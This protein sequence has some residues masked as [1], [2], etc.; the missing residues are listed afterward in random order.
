M[1]ERLSEA[2]CRFVRAFGLHRPERTPCGF[3]ASVAEAHALSELVAG[4]MRQRDLVSR[5]GLAKS[6]V[7]RLVDE[8]GRRGWVTSDVA[9]E[10]GRGITLALTA[11]GRS[12]AGELAEARAQRMRSLLAA[13]PPERRD[14]VIDVLTLLEEAARV[15]S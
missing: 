2:V 9:P 11:S 14:H 13:V 8:M 7:S 5:L 6:T 1:E 10:D 12:A 4:P 15:S 3:E